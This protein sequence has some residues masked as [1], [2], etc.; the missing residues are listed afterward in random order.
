MLSVHLATD[1]SMNDTLNR[2]PLEARLVSAA[3]IR[4]STSELLMKGNLHTDE[5]MR[6]VTAGTRVCVRRGASATTSPSVRA[7]CFSPHRRHFGASIFFPVNRLSRRRQRRQRGQQV[8]I[9][10]AIEQFAANFS[11]F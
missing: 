3:P 6:E 7:Q 1:R 11:Q 8:Q 4:Q 10:P 5:L 9:H 2:L